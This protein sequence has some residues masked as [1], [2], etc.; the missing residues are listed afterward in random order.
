[1]IIPY[2]TNKVMIFSRFFEIN[3]HSQWN[4]WRFPSPNVP[5]LEVKDR[6]QTEAKEIIHIKVGGPV[7]QLSWKKIPPKNVF[8]FWI[9]C[10]PN[11]CDV[12]FCNFLVGWFGGRGFWDLHDFMI[13]LDERAELDL[14]K[15]WMNFQLF[16]GA[17]CYMNLELQT[18]TSSVNWMMNQIFT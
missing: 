7:T 10:Q 5:I 9:V 13:D 16:I 2:P 3:Q 6:M 17:C 8:F 4:S 18:T 1:M 15:R 14:T 11:A 12:I